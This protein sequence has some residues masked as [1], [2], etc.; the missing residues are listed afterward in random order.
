MIKLHEN[1]VSMGDLHRYLIEHPAFIW[2]LGFPLAL[3]PNMLAG[4]ILSPACPP[5]T[6][7][8]NVTRHLQSFSPIHSRSKHLLCYWL[9][10]SPGTIGGRLYFFGYQTYPGLVKENNPKAYVSERFIN[11]NNPW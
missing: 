7:D 5:T 11:I 4:L 6:S 8:P 2:L 10:F 1:L 3:P 9:N